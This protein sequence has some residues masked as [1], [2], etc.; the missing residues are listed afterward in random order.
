MTENKTATAETKK[1]TAKDFASDQDVRWCP[2]CGDYSILA[3]VQRVLPTLGIPRENVVFV[4]GI[5]CSSRFPYYMNTYGFHG[6]HGRATAIASGIKVA[7]PELSVWVATGDGDCLSIGGNH[8][9]HLLRRNID[10]NIILFNNRIYGLTKGQYSPT[11]EKGKITRSSP[12]GSIDNPVDPIQLALGSSGTFIARGIDRDPKELQYV[13]ERASEHKGTSFIE[14]YQNC[15]VFNDGAYS[16]YTDKEVK[17][18]HVLILEHGKPLIFGK[19]RDKGIRLNRFFRPEVVPLDEAGEGDIVVHDEK[20]KHL[21]LVLAEMT[22]DPSL[23][24]PFG[25]F[26]AVDKPTYEEEYVK[27]IEHAIETEGRGTLKD[28]LESGNTW[29]IT[30]N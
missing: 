30:E 17:A 15:N 19:N 16:Q 28:L 5:G 29:D 21:A 24:T 26:Y 6:I 18:E 11:S 3:Q 1:L 23:P 25:V 4:A 20:N 10:V 14:V 2:G 9:V 27:Q 7:R 13:I 12:Y 8:F 22:D